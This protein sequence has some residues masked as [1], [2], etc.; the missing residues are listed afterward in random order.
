MTRVDFGKF[1]DLVDRTGVVRVLM[2]GTV[3]AN[4][5]LENNI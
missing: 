4:G 2:S 5:S 3:Y 1:V